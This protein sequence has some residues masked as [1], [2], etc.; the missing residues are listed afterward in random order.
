L[1]FCCLLVQSSIGFAAANTRVTRL[2][3]MHSPRNCRVRPRCTS[4]RACRH[5]QH[6]SS[7]GCASARAD[8]VNSP[9]RRL[10]SC[11]SPSRRRRSNRPQNC[12]C[13]NGQLNN[14]TM[15]ATALG[16]IIKVGT[17]RVPSG[18]ESLPG[19]V[20]TSPMTSRTVSTRP[21]TVESLRERT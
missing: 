6:P 14:P 18:L 17:R 15:S 2:S 7:A 12:A 13:R 19:A 8:L 3:R 5:A 10:R 21:A 11:A 4:Y 1:F 20:K 9:C 16:S